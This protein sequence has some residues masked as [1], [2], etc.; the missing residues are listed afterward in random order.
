MA[1]VEHPYVEALRTMP[2]FAG[3]S[4]RDLER[5]AAAA[6]PH[7]VHAGDHLMLERYHGELFWLLLEGEAE[8]VRDGVEVARVG[9]GDFLGELGLLDQADRSASVVATTPVKALYWEHEVLRDLLRRLPRVA[10]RIEQ[11][12][13]RRRDAD[14]SR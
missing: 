10:E 5:V 3:C 12:A 7:K 9:P 14:R 1:R 8:V 11:E 4:R 2:L 13:T 6:Q